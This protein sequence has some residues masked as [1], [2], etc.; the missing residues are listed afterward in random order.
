MFGV[1]RTER[2]QVVS[3]VI[4]THR[5]E[6]KKE[7]GNHFILFERP[8]SLPVVL[9]VVLFVLF[10]LVCRC[11]VERVLGVPDACPCPLRT[12][13][14]ESFA[15]LITCFSIHCL[16]VFSGKDTN[17]VFCG[18][19]SM[20]RRPCASS[21]CQQQIPFQ[22]D[23][24]RDYFALVRPHFNFGFSRFGRLVRIDCERRPRPFS[25]TKLKL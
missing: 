10:T 20:H 22:I 7:I 1:G 6:I 15:I 11:H 13:T 4:R 8:L 17:L 18:V 25:T 3:A 12:W 16:F 23:F 24:R 9:A 19:S 5:Q 2:W 14:I 21:F